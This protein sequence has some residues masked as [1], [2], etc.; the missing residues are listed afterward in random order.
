[1]NQ[2]LADVHDAVAKVI[3]D[4]FLGLIH[5]CLEQGVSPLEIIQEGLGRGLDAVGAK[6]EEGEYF[7]ADLIIA[8]DMVTRATGMLSERL[9]PGEHGVKGKVILATVKGDVHDIG[10]KVVGIMLAASGYEIIDLGADVPAAKIVGA[11]RET[12]A[13]MVGLSVLLTTMVYG[14]REVVAGL[15]QAGMRDGVKIAIG[16]A[17]CSPHL[18]EEMGVD[19]FGESA[20]AAVRIFDGFCASAAG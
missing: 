14:I 5:R 19:A 9:S 4:N 13:R 2:Y 15:T 12:G 17:C 6:F 10:K 8:G 18:A 20:I 3:D 16:G 7:L 1:M 11:I